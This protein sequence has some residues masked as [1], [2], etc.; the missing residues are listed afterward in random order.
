MLLEDKKEA[1]KFRRRAAHYMIQDEVLYK[2]SFSSPLLRCIGGEETYYFLREIYKE[3]CGNHIGGPT[4]AYKMLI[5]EHYL[6]T[7]KKDTMQFVRK[8]N[9]C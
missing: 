3:N 6:P 4:L 5:Q 9:K 1:H 2:R 7:L 8:C